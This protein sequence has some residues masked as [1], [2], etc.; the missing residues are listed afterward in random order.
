MWFIMGPVSCRCRSFSWRF[1]CLQ[2]ITFF[3]HVPPLGFLRSLMSLF[4]R[5]FR[6]QFT[7]WFAA[8][9][10]ETCLV[11][12]TKGITVSFDVQREDTSCSL[13]K[14]LCFSPFFSFFLIYTEGNSAALLYLIMSPMERYTLLHSQLDST[15]YLN[16]YCYVKFC[17]S[18]LW[19]FLN[20]NL[21]PCYGFLFFFLLI[22]YQWVKK[23]LEL[24]IVEAL[25]FQSVPLLQSTNIDFLLF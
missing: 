18:A 20:R 7:C 14:E 23:C 16:I 12:A 15:K 11:A 25:L 10:F 4:E 1:I 24:D 3:I 13:L 21:I 9:S 2:M 22:V 8:K 19:L 5:R 6:G 17:Q